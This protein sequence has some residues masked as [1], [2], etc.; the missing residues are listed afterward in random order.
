[1]P[2]LQTSTG[3]TCGKQAYIEIRGAY[4]RDL[5]ILRIQIAILHKSI[6]TPSCTFST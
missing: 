6:S 1:M 2:L 4:V 3:N 5:I